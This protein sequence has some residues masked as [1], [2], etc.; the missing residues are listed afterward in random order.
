V[1][2]LTAIVYLQDVFYTATSSFRSRRSSLQ[3]LAGR[4][5]SLQICSVRS[6][7]PSS[8]TSLTIA[9]VSWQHT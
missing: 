4:L 7:M 5:G 1:S 3:C 2:P 6:N 9:Q 8:F